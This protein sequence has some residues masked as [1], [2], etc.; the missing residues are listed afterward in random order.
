MES[1]AQVVGLIASF[2]AIVAP[3]A[4]GLVPRVGPLRALALA[5]TS[6]FRRAQDVSQRTDEL[7]T[8]RRMLSTVQK[9]QYVVVSGPKGVG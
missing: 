1:L 7:Q 4:V 8:L 5:L 2:A 9:D 3:P 6:R